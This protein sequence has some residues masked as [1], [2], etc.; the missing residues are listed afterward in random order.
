MTTDLMLGNVKR[1]V[2]VRA[3][4]VT[5]AAV[6]AAS[7]SAAAG[8][9]A[10]A[11]LLE[12]L[13]NA[14]TTISPGSNPRDA[15]AIRAAGGQYVGPLLGALDPSAP[16]TSWRSDVSLQPDERSDRILRFVCGLVLHLEALDFEL[17][18]C[19]Y[20]TLFAALAVHRKSVAAAQVALR[21]EARG[22]T[23]SD[24]FALD[25]LLESL[26]GGSRSTTAADGSQQLCSRLVGALL[27][28]PLLAAYRAFTAYS[29]QHRPALQAAA[30]S[31]LPA[32]ASPPPTASAA[33][34]AADAAVRA[35][36]HLGLPPPVFPA[37]SAAAN[38][39]V[40]A[41]VNVQSAWQRSGYP[42]LHVSAVHLAEEDRWHFGS[43][44]RSGL[45]FWDPAAEVHPAKSVVRRRGGGGGSSG[46]GG[47]GSQ[48][49]AAGGA[50]HGG[51]TTERSQQ[52]RSSPTHT[53]D[54]PQRWYVGAPP[55]SH[56]RFE[57]LPPHAPQPP[58]GD[59]LPGTS[60]ETAA[61]QLAQRRARDAALRAAAAAT[62]APE[63][64]GGSDGG[65]DA[66]AAGRASAAALPPNQ[67]EAL[68]IW[69][70]W[71]KRSSRSTRAYPVQRPP[72]LHWLPMPPG[73]VAAVE[74][75]APG[76]E[77]AVDALEARLGD[78]EGGDDSE[79][80]G[81]AGGGGDRDGGVAGGAGAAALPAGATD[82]ENAEASWLGASGATLERDG[83]GGGS[84]DEDDDESD[85]A[86]LRPLAPVGQ[87]D[88]ELRV[89]S[90][91]P[92]L[93]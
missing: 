93:Q 85:L 61:V 7:G 45:A 73:W 24:S 63:R 77:A 76:A 31:T 15:Q 55:K 33:T 48:M 27:P 72:Y 86:G 43:S 5:A 51:A 11:G 84:E 68:I 8:E 88:S 75:A 80:G 2:D 23:L 35:L 30:L 58:F 13:S 25:R 19:T 53:A 36:D 57:V 1:R 29:L 42:V 34:L 44:L 32:A 62:L 65:A 17:S 56:P 37:A 89:R 66:P 22:A 60:S 50:Q 92:E 69:E 87:E 81:G 67:P 82:V 14:P 40:K 4:T 83:G 41:A 12:V 49:D 78:S 28:P 26:R 38:A 64:L 20:R 18:D 16:F 21:L 91:G 47:G 70:R 6:T 54:N 74:D 9:E 3:A 71:V 90:P 46:G 39:A 10:G 59:V 52:P 79:A